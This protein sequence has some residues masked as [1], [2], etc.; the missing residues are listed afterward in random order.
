MSSVCRR[1][2]LNVRARVSPPVTQSRTAIFSWTKAARIV[3]KSEGLSQHLYPVLH[4]KSPFPFMCLFLKTALLSYVSHT[5]Q[6]T[7]LKCTIQC[8]LDIY[9]VVKSSSQS[10]LEFFH[11]PQKKLCTFYQ[12]PFISLPL[13]PRQLLICFLPLWIC[14]F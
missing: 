2:C 11:H 10:I 5:I 9:R 1:L 7:Q 8:F 14:L 3:L 6:F 12:V 4:F 13:N